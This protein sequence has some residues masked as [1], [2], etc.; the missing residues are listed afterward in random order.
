M[1]K[2]LRPDSISVRS[3]CIIQAVHRGSI[4]NILSENALD[5]YRFN[6]DIEETM[7]RVFL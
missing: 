4:L 2:S 6:R 1:I 5:I 7:E 3:Y